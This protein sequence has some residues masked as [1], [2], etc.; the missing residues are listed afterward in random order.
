MTV[1]APVVAIHE[2]SAGE[3]VGYGSTWRAERATRVATL[4]IG[5]ADGVP[6][7]AAR[8][9][10]MW[11]AGGEREIAGRVSMDYTSVELGDASVEVGDE[12]IVFGRAPDGAG[13]A[14]EEAAVHDGAFDY[15]LLVRVGRRVERE[16]IG[17]RT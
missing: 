7:T 2:L 10:R 17:A 13:L 4:A 12:A 15:E 16:T 5:Y 6:W 14:V 1:Y 11:L 3:T 8:R 9:G